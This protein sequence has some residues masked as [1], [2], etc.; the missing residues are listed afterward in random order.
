LAHRGR[1]NP[2]AL[3]QLVEAIFDAPRRLLGTETLRSLHRGNASCLIP[4]LEHINYV[5]GQVFDTRPGKIIWRPHGR[6]YSLPVYQ[7]TNGT[8]SS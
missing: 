6:P 8:N 7:H 4:R 5:L 2:R 1:Y 3:E